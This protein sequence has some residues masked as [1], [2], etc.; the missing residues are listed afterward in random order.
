MST[1]AEYFKAELR[2]SIPKI[3]F[4]DDL[5]N[6]LKQKVSMKSFITIMFSL[7]ATTLLIYACSTSRNNAGQQV[8]NY[9]PV[10]K[11]LYD[12]IVYYDS[13]LFNAFNNQDIDKLKIFFS[14]DLEFYH[15]LGGVTNYKQNIEAFKKTFESDRK[16]RRELVPGSLEVYPI[17]DFGA[18]ETGIHR[19]Y[20]T[21]KGEK[22]KLS[23]EAK[24][25]HVW[26]K[27]GTDW[28]ITRIISYAHQEYLKD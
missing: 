6:T 7:L 16:I 3:A 10:S 18:V 19:F 23:S 25:A 15:D 22:E 26:Q 1:V 8:K 2:C 27:K 5:H 13:L 4:P 28:K 20:V 12:T 14:E 17:K 9:S 24:F 21:E 11:D